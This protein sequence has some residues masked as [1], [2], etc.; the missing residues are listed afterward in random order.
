MTEFL[1]GNV[2]KHVPD[3]SI[4]DVKRLHPILQRGGQFPGGAS[5]LLE[6]IGAKAS[7]WGSDIDRLN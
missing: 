3:A 1:D 5:K 7:I 2:L 6:K 4:L